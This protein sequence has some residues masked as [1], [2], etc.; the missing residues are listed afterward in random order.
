MSIENV[1]PATLARAVALLQAG[2]L[3]AF[4]TETVY[5]LGADAANP[6]AVRRIYEVKGRPAD[7]PVIVHVADAKALSDWASDI[8]AAAWRLT[9]CYWPGP[10]TLVLKRAAG[11]PDIVTGGQDTIGLRSPDHPVAQALLRAFR[12]GKGGLAAPSANRYGRV[13]PT[14]AAHVYSEFDDAVPLILDGGAC[15]VGIESTILD[16]SRG[17]PVLLRPGHIGARELQAVLG[18]PVWL[19][20]GASALAGESVPT[21]GNAAPVMPATPR[22]SGSLTAHY[23]PRTP[24]VL[25][26]TEDLAASVRTLLLAGGSVGVWSRHLPVPAA[27]MKL[28]WREAPM[29]AVGFAQALYATLRELDSLGLDRLLIE[30]PPHA[31]DW[32]AVRDRLGRAVAGS[33]TVQPR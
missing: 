10:L 19:P 15:A 16:L 1:T 25:V 8:P 7:H 26:P 2:E 23:A 32:N 20:D 33:G 9:E 5:G 21:P 14:T 11:V 28:Q 13:S 17:K 3:V 29:D 22:V 6:Q 4:P 30:A 18:E 31:L 12:Q 24:M 27:G